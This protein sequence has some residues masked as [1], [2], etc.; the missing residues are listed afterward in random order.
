M[1][2]RRRRGA[3]TCPGCGSLIDVKERAC[4]SCGMWRPGLWGFGP[5][6]LEMR[7]LPF[8]ELILGW[9]AILYVGSLF[10][11]RPETAEGLTLSGALSP[12][13][14]GL[15][16]LGATGSITVGLYGR[17][18][19]LVTAIFLHGS[20]IHILFNGMWTWQ[21]APDMTELYGA[22][23]LL[24]I[25]IVSGVLGNLASMY[26]EPSLLLIGASGGV[27]G[28]FGALVWYGYRRGGIVGSRIF[29]LGAIFAGVGFVLSLVYP[30]IAFWAH[31]GG[32]VAG[33]G[34]GAYLGYEEVRR[35]SPRHCLLA[36]AVG[37]V[38]VGSFVAYLAFPPAELQ[39]LL[40][41]FKGHAPGR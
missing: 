30:G 34:C 31:A 15:F 10:L 17:W 3:V 29:R 13:P 5:A 35:T 27:Y 38:V 16:A 33:I 1:F 4:P 21:L 20:F 39:V 32:F 28:L 23:R 24:I 11:Y 6:L 19:T 9:C 37:L 14:G 25:F 12:S 41:A 22:P 8:R 18:E 7:K 36:A 26:L 2:E 40:D